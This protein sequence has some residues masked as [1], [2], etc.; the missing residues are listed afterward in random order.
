MRPQYFLSALALAGCASA[1]THEQGV[2]VVDSGTGGTEDSGS[3]SGVPQDA[4]TSGGPDSGPGPCTVTTRDLLMNGTF[5]GAGTGW[6]AVPIVANDP[7]VGD[8]SGGG[9]AAHSPTMRAWLGGV[10]QANA[11]DRLYQDV[12]VPASTTMLVLTGFYEVRTGESGATVYDTGKAE[13]TTTAGTSIEVIKALDNAQKTTTWTSLDHPFTNLAQM[14]G[15]TV[16]VHLTTT[17][18]GLN[19]TSFYFDTL[20]L[21]ATVCE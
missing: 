20:H 14:K 1:E 18:D 15:Q 6:T 4:P 2:G 13:I 21:N 19:A 10:A 12:L 8:N 16:R 11:T 17:N 5:E 9:I 7:L 3:G